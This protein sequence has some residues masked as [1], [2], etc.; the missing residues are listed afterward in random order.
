MVTPQNNNHPTINID[1]CAIERT[2]QAIT[3]VTSE[4]FVT[5]PSRMNVLSDLLIG[6][7]RF[8]NA[9]RWKAFFQEKAEEENNK[10]VKRTKELA[11][12][13]STSTSESKGS[14]NTKMKPSNKSKYAPMASRKVE[15][16]LKEVETT[17]IK[18]VNLFY[19]EKD[20]MKVNKTSKE[21]QIKDLTE[22]LSKSTKVVVPTDKP[23]PSL[24]SKKLNIPNGYYY[25]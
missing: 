25:T 20:K 19:D 13:K 8:R 3:S 14:L 12:D 4:K 16:F 17:L 18:Q 23:I 21:S 7:K 2:V 24:P 22:L 5:T 1:G 11:E 10:T 9:I 6:L 15:A